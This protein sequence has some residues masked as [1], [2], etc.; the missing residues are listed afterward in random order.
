MKAQLSIEN[1]A[2][3]N[4]AFK[5]K[6]TAPKFYVVKPNQSILDKGSK[7]NIDILLQP[8]KPGQPLD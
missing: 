8:G 7:I 6:T 2:N 5:I 1:V 4:I 3:G